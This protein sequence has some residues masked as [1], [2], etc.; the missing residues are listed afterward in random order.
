MSTPPVNPASPASE[1]PPPPAPLISPTGNT[2]VDA[3]ASAVNAGAQPF[4]QLGNPKAN[5]LDRVTNVVSG[6]VGSLGALDQLLNTGMAMIPGANLVPG[7]PA[8]FIGVPHL[9]VPHAHAHPPSD[10]VPMPS[11]G[12]TIGSGCLSVLYG[13]M[14]AARVLDIGLAPT[15]GG[16]APVFEICTGSSNTFIGGARAARMALDLTRHCN[17]LG[18]SGAGHAEQDAEKASALKRAMHIAGMAAPVASGGLTAADQ[19][20]DGAGA[21]AGEMT[22]A[23]TAADA[24]AMAM[25]NLMG[26][27]PGVEP[28]MGTLI[29]GDESV[30]IGG[31][32]MP[33]ALAMLMLGWGLR[34]KAHAPEDAGES[35][36]TEQGECKGGHPVDVVRGTAENEFTDYATVDAPAFKW[37]RY[38]RSDWSERDGALGFG[39]RHSFQHELRLLRTRAIYVDGPGRAYVFRRSASGRYEDVFAGYELEQQGENRFVL[40]H[41]THGKFTFDRASGVQASARLVRHVREGV[42]STVR[43]AGDG[44]LQHIEQTAGREQR[45]R[46]IDLLYDARGHVVEMR[47]TD[48]RGA[49]LCAARYRY[50]ATGCLVAST[51]ALGASMTYG[52]DAWRRMIR[53][54][55]ANGYSFSYRYDSGGRCVESAG[56]DGLWRVLLDYQPGRTVVTQ[57]D[58]G[59]W[60]YLYDAARTVTRIVDP[61]G[62]ATERVTGDDGRIVEEVDSGGRVMRWLYDER[63]DNTGRLD[64]W[65]NRWPTR[66]EAPQLP[67][68]LAHVVPARPLELLWG[69]ARP[70]DL[71]DR[72]LLPPEIEAVAV[73]AFASSAAVL[74]PA[75]ERDGA[76]RVIGSTDASG[77]S[78][79][80]SRDAAGNVVQRRDKDGHDYEYSIASWNL[81]ESET[82]PLGNTV[83]YR[84]SPKQE[85]TAI[86]D[87]NG[88]ESRY[89]YDYKGR[90]TRVARHDTIRESYVYDTGDRLIEKRDGAGNTL[91]R[92]EVGENG[93]HSKRILASGETHTYEYDRRG[94]FTRAS[95]DK[96][97]VTLTY[98]ANGRR[99]G[100]K[101]DGRGIE[102]SFVGE[103]LESTTYF[104]R[105]V[106]RY[107][108]G[109]TGDVV[110]HTPDG[111]VHRLQRAADGTVLVRLANRTNVLYRFDS[112]GR[113]TGRLNWPEG[114]MTEIHCVQYQYSA[115]GEL[116]C[117]IDSTGGTTEYQY[118]AAH[119]LVGESRDGWTVRR[120]EYD[121]GG[122]L[123]STP[124]CQWM[125]YTEG[126]RLSGAA[127]GAF[128][129]NSRNHLAEQIGENNRRT[130][131]QY[132]SMDLLVRVQWSDRQENWS[133]EYDGLCRRIAKAMGHARTQYFWDGDRLAA[134]VAPNGQLRI[135]AYVNETSYL[136]FMF[137][138]YDGCDAAPESGRTY[139]VFCNQ[140]GL[141]EWIEDI[142]GGCV[143]SVNEIDPYGA[144]CVAPGNELE[145]NLRWPGHWFD[146]E[147]GLHYN[148]FRSY[149]P[150]LGRYLQSDPAGQA[151]GINLYA[152]TAN[153]LV[154]IDVLGRECPHGNES[155]SE[156]SQCADREEAARI[157]QEKLQL[158]ARR[159]EIEEEVT[160]HPGTLLAPYDLT[161]KDSRYE[162]EYKR[163]LNDINTKQE[164]EDAALLREQFPS[165]DAV[166]LPPFDGK[167]TI[168]YMFYTDANGQYHV[169]KL[170]SGGKVLSNYD[171]SGHVEGN[172]A[173]IMRDEG[174]TEAVVIHNHPYGTCHYCYGQVETLLPKNA[175]L[176]VIPPENAI[177][178]TKYWHDQPKDYFGN[179]ADPKPPPN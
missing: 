132:N 5:T 23:Q 33:D 46:M 13:G 167:T 137:I 173:L 154:L 156:C 140:V 176:R 31:F 150:V 55:D 146:P 19:A 179:S 84:Y 74:E 138:D 34:K 98:D 27:D 49:V 60:T 21:A 56:Q 36:R 131:W 145:Y 89:T 97:E 114:R 80:L 175:K 128:C 52:Y 99:T 117:A 16:F 120:F 155:S 72:L 115:T 153:P 93:L 87:A 73:A 2:S 170:Y 59:K 106:A 178:P 113:C 10:G 51:D 9:G 83:R 168:G 35:K 94:N 147:T 15:C 134:E 169:R 54:T 172:A 151:G 162:D 107:D 75:E 171:S 160:G 144:I 112:D 58:G 139:Y 24:I 1:P 17:P 67:N 135:Y 48:P 85:I 81:R 118:D 111:G 90:L 126:N 104:S 91:L 174:I 68:P 30:L 102:H 78:E 4:Q 142:S 79:C 101:R 66:D 50:D 125:R 42:E 41:A 26:K 70:E 47:V 32:P 122:N 143:W 123:L 103:R 71:T 3:L 130:T 14:P 6:A 40:L 119:R 12:V 61:Y 53:E 129:Y 158:I 38:Y 164:A 28:G 100:D 159:M 62:G 163:L 124:T 136:P 108:A 69:D 133:A 161:G 63:G 110:I 105:F 165:M 65:G 11:C 37:E 141:P 121:R 45:R 57:A 22:A 86:V 127:C 29:D 96:F 157:R 92:F 43:Y 64:R 20:V 116:Q 18:M 152:Y 149:S 177:A 76:G 88:N 39:F 82:D 25:S 166:T 8:A 95:T 44:T 7:M 148:R 109:P 77:H